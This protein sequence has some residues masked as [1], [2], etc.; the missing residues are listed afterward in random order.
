MIENYFHR[1]TI[2]VSHAIAGTTGN[3]EEN[4][5]RA[6]AGV[7][8][9]RRLFPE[10]NWY[11][12][13]GVELPLKVLRLGK[14]ISV[15]DVL[16]ADFKILRACHGWFFYRFEESSGSERERKVAIS[17][18]LVEGEEHDVRYD[19]SKASY[20][21]IRKTFSPIVHKTIRRYRDV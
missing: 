17:A 20:T 13:A 6:I 21:A 2:Y 11:L 15:E 4:C 7:R 19:I 14:K 9:L 16:W 10:V 8:K 3:E 18:N 1:P 12:P 5:E